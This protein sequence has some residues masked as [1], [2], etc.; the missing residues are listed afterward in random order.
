MLGGLKGQSHWEL[1]LGRIDHN[2]LRPQN[3]CVFGVDSRVSK[4]HS[5]VYLRSKTRPKID[6]RHN[7]EAMAIR[8]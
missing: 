6:V 1:R 2:I 3:P 7:I 8:Q 5:W 4:A